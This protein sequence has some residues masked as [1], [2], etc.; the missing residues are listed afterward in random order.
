MKMKVIFWPCAVFI[1][2]SCMAPKTQKK[3][4]ETVKKDTFT[5][6]EYAIPVLGK[7]SVWRDSA[8]RL[9]T[10]IGDWHVEII[11]RPN[12]YIIG[13]GTPYQYAD[14]S[15]FLTLSRKEKLIYKNK[16]IRT[17]DVVG[18]EGKDQLI[19]GAPIYASAST[20]YL[21][22]M[23]CMPETDVMWNMLYCI[24]PYRKT[25]LYVMSLE[26]GE[27]EAGFINSLSEFF[28]IYLHQKKIMRPTT[29]QMHE[30]FNRYCTDHIRHQLET[31]GAHA[32]DKI[33]LRSQSIDFEH[34]LNTLTIDCDTFSKGAVVKFVPR[35]H[36]TDTVFL[37]VFGS[38]PFKNEGYKITKIE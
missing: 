23:T 6:S 4:N 19:Y 31:E 25:D 17:K 1:L 35:P 24:T 5:T 14:N 13:K 9:D 22:I 11:K 7:D 8:T 37:R 18:E 26:M 33:I 15:L 2:V 20:M 21:N 12:N 28:T 10:V 3:N 29:M 36:H 27:D 16:E 32:D 38:G 30:L 34:A